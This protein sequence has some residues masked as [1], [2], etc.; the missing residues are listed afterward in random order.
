MGEEGYI[1]CL[2]DSGCD[3]NSC[4][5][6]PVG[7]PN[8]E[9]SVYHLFSLAPSP[10]GIEALSAVANLWVSFSSFQHPYN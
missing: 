4:V 10:K 6:S 8:L 9:L 1:L 5:F 3:L 2:V 7:P